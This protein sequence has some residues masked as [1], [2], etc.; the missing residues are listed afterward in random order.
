MGIR[1]RRAEETR[2]MFQDALIAVWNRKKCHI[3]Q[4]TVTE[5]C[6]QAGT[7]RNTFYYYYDDVF[8]LLEEIE[9]ELLQ[10]HLFYFQQFPNA[11]ISDYRLGDPF[12]CIYEMHVHMKEKEGYYRA[13]MGPYG[14]PS[15]VFKTKKIVKDLA[16]K[17]LEFDG[18]QVIDMDF[19]LELIASAAVGA[20]QYWLWSKPEMT[21][22]EVSSIVGRFIYGNLYQL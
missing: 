17:K 21:P 18:I 12:P 22:F 5:L 3:D 16:R 13:L 15:F 19:Q 11:S 1:R 14:E 7:S 8:S 4:V 9:E 2:Q 20:R 10:V 6:A